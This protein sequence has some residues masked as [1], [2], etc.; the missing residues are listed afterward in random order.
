[1][2]VK[3]R[4]SFRAATHLSMFSFVATGTYLPRFDE[5]LERILFSTT[6]SNFDADSSDTNSELFRQAGV[7]QWTEHI[8]C[9]S[10]VFEIYRGLFG[11]WTHPDRTKKFKKNAKSN[12]YRKV[13]R[14]RFHHD[15]SLSAG[16]MGPP[17]ALHRFWSPCDIKKSYFRPPSWTTWKCPEF[18]PPP[19]LGLARK[20]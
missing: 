3:Q 5:D 13:P 8:P 6:T 16:I 14:T 4:C 17:Q 7:I 1:M 20:E 10:I 9:G 19:L 2:Q 11:I 15:V 18:K 12:P